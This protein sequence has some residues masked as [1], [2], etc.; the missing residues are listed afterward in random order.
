MREEQAVVG[1]IIQP[2]CADCLKQMRTG[3]VSKLI[4]NETFCIMIIRRAFPPEGLMI[5]CSRM[6]YGAT[7]LFFSVSRSTCT[8]CKTK[9]V[10]LSLLLTE[11]RIKQEMICD[12]Q[13]IKDTMSSAHLFDEL[14]MIAI[15]FSRANCYIVSVPILR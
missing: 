3:E 2:T 14:N 5:V 4:L 11:Q 9:V 7:Q 8:N 13:I 1:K 10:M 6:N 12:G 15:F